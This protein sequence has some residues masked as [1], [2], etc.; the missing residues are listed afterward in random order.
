MATHTA[1]LS[2]GF[3]ATRTSDRVYT[4][5]VVLVI[6]PD[7]TPVG[8]DYMDREAAEWARREAAGVK[9]PFASVEA[10]IQ[11]TQASMAA[12]RESVMSWSMSRANAEKAATKTRGQYPQHTVRVMEV[13]RA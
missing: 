10:L 12:G 1:I 13:T 4:H 5:A 6:A 9:Q 2:N 3:K 8:Q 11:N 7:H